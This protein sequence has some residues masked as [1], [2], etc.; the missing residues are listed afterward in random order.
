[1]ARVMLDARRARKR[2]LLFKARP[3]GRIHFV[4]LLVFVVVVTVFV[5]LLVVVVVTVLA[6]VFVVKRNWTCGRGGRGG[7]KF[8]A[9][10]DSAPNGSLKE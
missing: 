5:D 10:A 4:L 1:M 3:P 9:F 6:I 8:F 2:A 7:G